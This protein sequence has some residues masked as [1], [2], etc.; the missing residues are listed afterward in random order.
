VKKEVYTTK[1]R[2][3]ILAAFTSISDY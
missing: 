3:Q 2:Y 1:H